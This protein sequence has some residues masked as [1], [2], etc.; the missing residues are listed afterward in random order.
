M[1]RITEV[2]EIYNSITK[3]ITSD[4][5]EWIDFLNFSSNVY[6]YKF[7][8]AL[9]IYAQKPDATMVANMEIWNR[10][11]GRYINKGTRSIAVFDTT[12]QDLKL[13]YLFDIKDTHGDI[14]TIPQ[15]WKLNEDN[16]NEVNTR[17][18]EKYNVNSEKLEDLIKEIVEI[19]VNNNLENS[20]EKMSD[21]SLISDFTQIA[22]ESIEHM[23]SRRCNLEVSD[24]NKFESIKKF[25]TLQLTFELG[26]I[27]SNASQEIL[28]EI[29]FEVKTIEK[30]R[31]LKNYDKS[32][33]IKLSREIWNPLSRDSN[34]EE[35]GSGEQAVREVRKDG[36]EIS[37]REL[38]SEVQYAA[39]GRKSEGINA[40][41]G[42]RSQRDVRNYNE[43]DVGKRS[44][45]KSDRHNGNLQ[46]QSNDKGNSRRNSIK[47]DSIQGEIESIQYPFIE[48]IEVDKNCKFIEDA[49]YTL[50]NFNTQL[51]LEES[52]SKEPINVKFKMHLWENKY[53]EYTYEIK[54]EVI[55][56]LPEYISVFGDFSAKQLRELFPESKEDVEQAILD[57][58]DDY[59]AE[60]I[61]METL[62]QQENEQI[63]LDLNDKSHDDILEQEIEVIENDIQHPYVEIVECENEEIFKIGE[64]FSFDQAN[65]RYE[66]YEK[67]L[68]EEHS[69]VLVG[70]KLYL[71]KE[72]INITGHLGD[73]WA[74]DLMMLI[75]KET[76]LE[77]SEIYKLFPNTIKDT[78]LELINYKYSP[79]DEIGAGGLK[80]KFKNNIEAIQTLKKLETEDRIAT[81]EEQKILAKYVGWGGMP[82][83]FDENSSGWNNEYHQLKSLLYETDYRSAR[84]SVNNSHYTSD[85]VIGSIYKALDSF[86]FKDGN[87]LEPSMGIGNFF[88]HVPEKMENSNLYG[89]EIDNIS[90]RIAK[91]LYQKA[92]IEVKGFEETNYPNNFFDV[93]IGNVP[94][95]DYK[96][97]DRAY[98]KY[99][100]KIHDYFFAKTLDKVRPGGVVA[101]VTSKGTLD[102]ANNSVRK[103][104]SER[105]DLIGAIRLPNTAF[106]ANANTEVTTD[107]IFLQKKEKMSVNI[108][109][110]NWIHIGQTED[111]VPVNE[112]FIDNPDMLLGK[113]V[114]D[115]K[116]FGEDSKYTTLINDDDNFNLEDSLNRAIEKLSA[117]IN[118]FDKNLDTIEGDIN[119]TIPA[120]PNVRNYTYTFINNELYYRENSTM[121]KMDEIKG[122]TLERI[123]GL[124]NIRKITREIIDIQTEGCTKEQLEEK[125]KI[126]N[127]IYDKFV[128]EYGNIN[129]KA[130][131]SAFRDDNDYPLISSLEVEKSNGEIVKADM[132][133]KQ[134]IKPIERITSVDTAHEALILSLNEV[135]KVDFNLIKDV[136][137]KPFTEIIKELKGDIYLNPT[138]FNENNL[139][140]GW[141]P[142][143]EY[144]SGDVKEKLKIA[145][146]YAQTNDIF[147][148]NVQALENSLPTDLEASEIDFRL[149]TNWIET[150][151]YENFMYELLDTPAYYRSIDDKYNNNSRIKVHYNSY[152][153]SYS[154][155]NKSSDS[156]VSSTQTYGTNRINA[157]AIVEESLNLRSVTVRDK[158]EDDKYV[159]NQKE[160]M[161]ARE[162]QTQIKEEFK[163]WLFKDPERRKKYVDLYNERFNNIRLR[164]YNGEHLTLP[165]INP[166]IQ[167]RP[168]QK[169]AIA[170]VVYGGNTLLAHCVGAG[171][172]FEMVASCMEL[173]RLGI[174]K[175]S[176]MV[177]PNHLTEQMGA[178][179]LRLYPSANILVTTKKD[180]QKQNRRKFISKIAT[181]EYDAVIIGH[182]QFEKIPISKERE[183]RMLRNQIDEITYSISEAKREDGNRWSIKQM[184][185]FK[186]GLEAEMKSLLDTPKDDV[187]NF[188][189]LGIDSMFVDEAH[190]YKN[191][192]V[193]TKMRNVAGIATTKAKKSTDMLMKCQY[194]EEINNGKGVVFATGTPISNS[195]TELFV[196]QRYLQN[197]ELKKRGI[198]HFDAWAANFGEITAS[199]E[200][201]PEGKGYRMRNRFSKLTNLPEL[202]SIF[203]EIADIQ[204]PDMLKLPVPEIKG[205]KAKDIV[206]EPSEFAQEKMM[207]F[208]ERAEEIRKGNVYPNIDNML[209]ITNEA[210][211]LGTDPRLLDVNAENEPNSKLNNCI[212]NIIKEYEESNSF[213]GT[214]I[215]FCDI[216]TPNKDA[217]FTVYDY[218]KEELINRGINKDEICFIHDANNEA[219]REKLFSD[220]RSGEKRIMIGSTSKLGVGTNIQDRLTCIHHLDCPYRPADIEQRNGRIL[221]QGNICASVNIYKYVTKNTFDSF[222]W[223]LVEK[224]QNMISQIMTSKS[225]ART[226]DD[227]DDVAVGYAETKALATGDPHIKEK[228]EID[229]D[230]Q[231][232]RMLKASYDNKKYT[233]QDNF[234]FKYPN[235]I[236]KATQRLNSMKEDIKIRDNNRTDEFSIS[237]NGMTFDKREE[238]GAM[239]KSL[240]NN[241]GIIG[242]LNGFN[243]SFEKTSFGF[244]KFDL[245]LHGNLKYRVEL[246]ENLH[247]NI[248][249]AEKTLRD[250]DKGISEIEK[251][252]AEYK[253]NLEQSKLEY[254]KPFPYIDE[255]KEKIRRQDELNNMLSL[256]SNNNGE[257][258]EDKEEYLTEKESSCREETDL[259]KLSINELIKVYDENNTGGNRLYMSKEQ[260]MDI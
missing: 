17:L 168:H 235:M 70:F 260:D 236:N 152:D 16:I 99:N 151:D 3:N 167:L 206:S 154:I 25:N 81:P 137:N 239:L 38:S 23:V 86:G 94:F 208:A 136:Y 26:T 211:L 248:M 62:E 75:G 252:I 73:G 9:L 65:K 88:A 169:N 139:E 89:V 77:R 74:N 78:P 44:N 145:K 112:Y 58:M 165:G 57:H 31:R 162:K 247:N 1:N 52:N 91:Q 132:F 176:I 183:E 189:Q 159:V 178:E 163:N 228:M 82:Q 8:N 4:K 148:E 100:F 97:H 224:K 138:K 160:T 195:I 124:D 202:M 63:S 177:V 36:N 180:F 182:S 191:C 221:R 67:R 226:C 13:E 95:G 164:E 87:I 142:Q 122:T 116:M 213:K 45:I 150:K 256:D 130:N 118:T 174:S 12:N 188:E 194:I 96:L 2:K 20:F 117:N 66:I 217:D 47:R 233:M 155:S 51:K 127:D 258:A 21:E 238:A 192:F 158:T 166:E 102:K 24:D 134:T 184:E 98:D 42:Q 170:R 193:F 126:L 83:A 237:L 131:N 144:L 190:N 35:P 54:S 171:K 41:S 90:G 172:S 246:S 104:L 243:L 59:I 14:N 123:K 85:V 56:N 49:N 218:I 10:R 128:K 119:N 231:R 92:N 72:E 114:F 101:F 175:K 185:R 230:L 140:I 223:Q 205:G 80:T 179:F 108:E 61:Y 121:S 111:E 251:D 201:A 93:A 46:T 29:E 48:V 222:L 254:E 242:N 244:N 50:D 129:S 113:M 43:S 234:T 173:H 32:N 22:I 249:R 250:L 107:I 19:K 197:N 220:M 103:Y 149:G 212:D 186:K 245:V 69:E 161:I 34:I 6:K 232:L 71:E 215:V 146:V 33:E 153:C 53:Q 143:D 30:E 18:K 181:G 11:V 147:H 187:I 37:S 156:S 120:D 28:K 219:Q 209:K 55:K 210:R 133:T 64:T 227:I 135:G 40:S 229:N 196:M 76:G 216:G 203:K 157:Y 68:E 253:R 115:S 5:N 27:V 259:S 106:K 141:E 240:E 84:A 214:Q 60:K 7:D 39:S 199:L 125:Q 241:T 198:E 79:D 110:P 204:T 105:A 15:L 225:I 257:I 207:E 109:E 255:L 200:L